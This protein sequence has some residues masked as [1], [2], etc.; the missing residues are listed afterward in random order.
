[1]KISF[2]RR[3]F[4]YFAALFSIYTA[5]IILFVYSKERTSKLESLETQLEIYAN[6]IHS[7][8]SDETTEWSTDLNSYKDLLPADLRVTIIDY[9][10][11]VLYENVFD[12][13]SIMENHADRIEIITAEERGSGRNIRKSESTQETYL[14]YAKRFDNHYVRVALPYDVKL[15]KFLRF[16]DLFL[17]MIIT[18]FIITLI[19]SHKISQQFGNSI[20]R[21][22]DFALKSGNAN[23][24]FN[25]DEL[26]EI[27]KKIASN[28]HQ[29]EENK[30]QLSL[31]KQK[32]LQHIQIS[33]EGICFI[34]ATKK[35]EFYNG[36]FVQYLNQLIDTNINPSVIL[37]DKTFASLHDFL[38]QKND[39][40]FETQINK[41]GKIFSLRANVFQD[42]SFEII[43]TDITQKERTRQLKQE[44]TG[45]IAHELRT[46]ITSV[47]AYL[48]TVLEHSLPADKREHF[49]KQAYHQT[50]NLS[51]MIKDMSV[52][53]KLEEA[54]DTFT[55]EKVNLVNLLMDLKTEQTIK[56][57]ENNIQMD[58][59][60]PD[61]LVVVGNS[62]L[63]TSIFRNLIE[64]SVRYAGENIKINISLINQDKDFYY[65][66]YYD[67]GVGVKDSAHLNRLFERF[68]RVQEG[69]TR[70]TGGSG[71]GLSIVKNAIIFH[72]GIISVKNRKEGGLEFLF[73]LKK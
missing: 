53:A 37:E 2:R 10:G 72:K 1:M 56:F 52:I 21:L 28:Y 70:E 22:R 64:N 23:V 29:L 30:K 31:E 11:E 39:D 40:Y 63:L 44:M 59:Q 20:E 24:I 65:F 45:N 25:D 55:L 35:V 8:L 66:S 61:D 6:F 33:E 5:G 46:P 42:D 58:W 13:F 9:Q 51:E 17:Y 47:R 18:F 38:E 12:D 62:N 57:N 16:D 36:L 48:E 27:G 4:L 49:I 71:L 15:K 7:A 41:Q 43:L 54:P 3:L 19:I 14:Y 26:G 73:S 50:L 69:R 60:L 68:Y 34:S 32:L 67:T